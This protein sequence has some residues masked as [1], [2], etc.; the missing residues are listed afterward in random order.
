[1][2]D[3]ADVSSKIGGSDKPRRWG[4]VRGP[5]SPPIQPE[6]HGI[7]GA[8][9]I[10]KCLS[11][12][13]VVSAGRVL[14]RE[15]N[16]VRAVL[17]IGTPEALEWLDWARTTLARLREHEAVHGRHSA[18]VHD[19]PFAVWAKREYEQAGLEWPPTR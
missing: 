8:K 1:M 17:R 19:H 5:N 11:A 18:L 7:F 9:H 13:M 16:T 4:Y 6:P 10:E 14:D 15:T 3:V 2:S 12:G